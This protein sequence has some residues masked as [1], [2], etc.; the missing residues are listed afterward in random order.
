M[1]VKATKNCIEKLIAEGSSAAEITA[2]TLSIVL[3]HVPLLSEKVDQAY[4]AAENDLVDSSLKM[5]F[6]N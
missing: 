2:M 4:Q 5:L 6:E 3:I 1:T